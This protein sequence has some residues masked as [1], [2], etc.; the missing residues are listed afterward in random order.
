MSVFFIN[1]FSFAAADGDYESIAT[2]TVGSGGAA[3]VQFSSIPSTYQHLQWRGIFKATASNGG[4][5][6]LSINGTNLGQYHHL[7]GD[8]SAIGGYGIAA[9]D[10]NFFGLGLQKTG[11]FSAFVCDILDYTSTSKNKVLRVF[12][13]AD[14]NSAGSVYLFSMLWQ[15][16]S[17]ITSL[18]LTP[19]SANWVQHSTFALYGIKAP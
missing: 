9:S 18:T 17:A 5:P 4:T 3:S 1:P 14:D 19:Q 15:S 10:A 8:G 7:A 2:V 11:P 16:T 6:R 13:G 12:A